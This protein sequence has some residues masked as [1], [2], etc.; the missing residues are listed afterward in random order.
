MGWSPAAAHLPRVPLRP[1]NM[2]DAQRQQT[3]RVQTGRVTSID[4]NFVIEKTCVSYPAVHRPQRSAGCTIWLG[5][6]SE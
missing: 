1:K 5:R 3:W 2:V 6:T 4:T